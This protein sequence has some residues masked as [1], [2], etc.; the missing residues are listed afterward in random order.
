[1]GN[2]SKCGKVIFEN[3][4]CPCRY[5]TPARSVDGF[6]YWWRRFQT[7]KELMEGYAKEHKCKSVEGAIIHLLKNY[8]GTK[9]KLS[10]VSYWDR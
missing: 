1:V 7:V 3:E 8:K 5:S 9:K 6:T 10:G 4:D 2:C